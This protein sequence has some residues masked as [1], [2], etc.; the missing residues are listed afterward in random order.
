MSGDFVTQEQFSQ[1]LALLESLRDERAKAATDRHSEVIGKIEALTTQQ[2]EMVRLQ[3]VA[4]GRTGT[5]EGAVREL[6]CRRQGP[7]AE[8]PS[9]PAGGLEVTSAGIRWKPTAKQLKFAATALGGLVSWPALV[10]VG[11]VLAW[12]SQVAGWTK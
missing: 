2:S 7:P 10:K 11:E 1:T 3:K 12:L 5:L 9:T 8:C 4:N 6:P